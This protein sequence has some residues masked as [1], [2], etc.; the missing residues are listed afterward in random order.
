LCVLNYIEFFVAFQAGKDSGAE[1]TTAVEAAATVKEESSE[2]AIAEA[3]TLEGE[4]AAVETSAIAEAETLEIAEAETSE[5]TGAETEN[6]ATIAATE[7]TATTAVSEGSDEE[8]EVI[9]KAE[10][11]VAAKNAT[12][13]KEEITT[14]EIIIEI[15]TVEDGI[16]SSCTRSSSFKKKF[17]FFSSFA[18]SAVYFDSSLLLNSFF[19][20]AIVWS[21][22][23][24]VVVE[25]KEKS[26]SKVSSKE[27]G[28]NFVT[29]S[30]C[31]LS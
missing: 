20:W 3:E 30:I 16:G 7:D 26:A 19:Q 21:R 1:K 31:V 14:I 10:T 18:S 23:V 25:Q 13:A 9:A 24:S 28:E 29:H 12:M 17:P 8:E 27:K 11:T 22:S 4:I 15:R 5:E 6:T 2:E